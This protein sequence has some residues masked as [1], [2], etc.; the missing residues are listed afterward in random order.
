MCRSCPSNTNEDAAWQHGLV[1]SIRKFLSNAMIPSRL[2]LTSAEKL[3]SHVSHVVADV[4]RIPWLNCSG[5]CY[6]MMS[7]SKWSITSHNKY[8]D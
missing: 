6:L 2:L 8:D 5:N 4:R 3:A 1:N 7:P